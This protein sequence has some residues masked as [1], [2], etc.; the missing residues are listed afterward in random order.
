MKSEWLIRREIVAAGRQ[1]HAQ[2]LI[3]G[4]EGNLSVR[5]MPE[6]FLVTP[7]GSALHELRPEDLLY[8]DADATVLARPT[9]GARPTSELP[10]HLAAYAAR[11][12]IGAVIHAHPPAT[13]ALSLAGLSLRTPVLPEI[14][15]TF[16]SVPTAPY[17]TPSTD[18][19]AHAIAEPIRTHDAILLERHGAVTVGRDLAEALHRME[20][21]EQAARI[22]LA[23]HAAGAPRP[24]P[25]EEIARLQAMRAAR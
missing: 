1:L 6:R 9:P 14:L 18:A 8:V 25:P 13:T 4:T 3:A 24:L 23:A 5:L 10:M 7:A 21:L 22:V 15:L 12:E 16:G 20:Q 11:P 2:G 19:G 17:A